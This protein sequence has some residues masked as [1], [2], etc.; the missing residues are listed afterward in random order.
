MPRRPAGRDDLSQIELGGL[1]TRM[2]MSCDATLINSV[3]DII[4]NDMEIT[5]DDSGNNND[6]AIPALCDSLSDMPWPP[7]PRGCIKTGRGSCDMLPYSSRPTVVMTRRESSPS[8]PSSMVSSPISSTKAGLYINTSRRNTIS[9]FQTSKN[10]AEALRIFDEGDAEP[11]AED[12]GHEALDFKGYWSS[13]ACLG[14]RATPLDRD[15]DEVAQ[16]DADEHN[17]SIGSLMKRPR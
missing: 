16:V 2:R 4:G 10:L 8:G 15:V 7:G 12:E 11:E 9:V 1:R 13:P 14:K 5:G 3:V 6:D 17:L